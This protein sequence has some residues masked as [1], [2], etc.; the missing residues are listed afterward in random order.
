MFRA[1]E[2]P[3]GR[4]PASNLRYAPDEEPR[5]TPIRLLWTLP[6]AV[7]VLAA[8]GQTAPPPG[9]GRLP[10][11]TTSAGGYRLS[12]ERIEQHQSS[13]LE[14]P[15]P[16]A[17]PQPHQAAP[18]GRQEIY[19]SLAAA[20][21]DPRMVARIERIE[22]TGPQAAG[23]EL[24]FVPLR[25]DDYHPLTA[26]RWRGRVYLQGL[27]LTRRELPS[28]TATLIVFA[29]VELVRVEFPL[30][31]DGE[32]VREASGVR[33]SVRKTVGRGGAASV[34]VEWLAPRTVSVDRPS[35]ETPTGV[36]AFGKR[37]GVLQPVGIS[38]SNSQRNGAALR[39]FQLTFAP[40][41]EGPARVRVEALVRS[42]PVERIPL[43]LPPVKLPAAGLHDGLLVPPSREQVPAPGHPLF[44]E[45]GAV[46]ELTLVA[47]VP[48]EGAALGLGLSRREG[49][50]REPW[51]W[52]EVRTGPDGQARLENLAPGTYRVAVRRAEGRAGP[53]AP[54]GEFTLRAGKS[55]SLGR[56]SLGGMP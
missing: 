26:D 52:L 32:Q 2:S 24:S 7:A 37:G 25:Q 20:P 14:F 9:P 44:R 6:F 55:T 38:T 40:M 21:P 42:G 47:P 8:V 43:A 33:F 5:L 12:V 27:E 49:D 41:E 48:A 23:G 10:A 53:A 17:D 13:Y 50:R 28:L 29:K 30:T 35:S 36:T 31:G 19:L 54:L 4:A 15:A 16:G 3:T 46:L 18:R 45:G 1:S 39:Q 56:V 11:P 51:R 22:L 34:M